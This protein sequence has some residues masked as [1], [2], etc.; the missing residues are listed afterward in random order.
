[1]NRHFA[2]LSGESLHFTASRDSGSMPAGKKISRINDLDKK[3]K[4]ETGKSPAK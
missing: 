4:V 1:M 3:V 2:P